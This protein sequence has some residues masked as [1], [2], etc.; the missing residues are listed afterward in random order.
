MEVILEETDGVGGQM[1]E[2]RKLIRKRK[3]GKDYKY[4]G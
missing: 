1:C 3:D 4:Q 2:G